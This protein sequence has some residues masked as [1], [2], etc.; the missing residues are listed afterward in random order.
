MNI[1]KK[2]FILIF[3]TNLFANFASGREIGLV[4]SLN[5]SLLNKT[6]ENEVIELDPITL[7]KKYQLDKS[8]T[9]TISLDDGTIF[10]FNNE[11]IFQF[12]EYE[13]VFSPSPHFTLNVQ[14]GEFTVE[15]GELPKLAYNATII[16]T[17]S[18]NLTLNGTAVSGAFNGNGQS[19]IFLLT[20]SF[21]NKGELTLTT[22][23]GETIN[24]EPDAGV[25]ISESGIL[26]QPLSE[27]Q[28]SKMEE[29]K[30]TIVESAI[31]DETKIQAMIENK[32]AKGKVDDLNGDGVVNEKDIELLKNNLL[33]KKEAKLDAIV[34][35]TGDDPTLLGKIISKVPEDKAGAVLEKVIAD[36]P[37]ATSKVVADVLEKNNEKFSALT[38]SNKDLSEKI[39][40]TV[41]KEADASDGALSKIIAKADSELSSSLLKNVSEKKSDL[42]VKVVS[43]ASS[44]DPSKFN[45]LLEQNNDLSSQVTLKMSEKILENPD[46]ATKLKELIVQGG[47]KMSSMIVDN[48]EKV[49]PAM[50]QAAL[51]EAI[52]E[53][54]EEMVKKLSDSV[55][56]N[57]SIANKIIKEAIKQGDMNIVKEA[58][59]LV[60]SNKAA[61]SSNEE[62]NNN[63]STNSQS[64]QSASNNVATEENLINLS[65]SINEA[66]SE[67]QLTNPE[68]L[69][70]NTLVVLQENLAS[71]N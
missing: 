63:T 4:E 50:S 18:G 42:L 23:S 36:N 26:P 44:A 38:S 31:I 40:N 56:E 69:N 49:N 27:E 70:N 5:G 3:F 37:K 61:T 16:K 28:N 62:V 43:E 64:N 7:N 60:V 53:N 20:D 2:I 15:T 14:K 45:K 39:I 21:G 41:V 12:E 59:D 55:G 71:P 35:Q 22:A 11:A 25:S 8:G 52:K 30:N 32:I 66:V 13:D 46:S 10:V 47:S 34:K 51:S 48:I 19:D 54:R 24:V 29:L 65:K 33:S 68:L 58:S 57:N 6:D 17:P 1:Q 67:I 9:L